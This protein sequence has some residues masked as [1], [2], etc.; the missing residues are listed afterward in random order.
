MALVFY[1]VVRRHMKWTPRFTRVDAQTPLP[2]ELALTEGETAVGWY[3]NPP[4]HENSVLVFTSNAIWVGEK[5]AFERVAM[6]DI[7]GLD[8]PRKKEGVEGL[9]VHTKRGPCFMRACGSFGPHGNS[10]DFISLM[11]VLR[12][13]IASVASTARFVN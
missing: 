10:K 3:R 12:A 7:V 2:F 11:M 9:L 5:G 1:S 13:V 4:P 8:S 6:S